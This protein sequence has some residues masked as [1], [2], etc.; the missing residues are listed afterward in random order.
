MTEETDFLT[1]QLLLLS[2]RYAEQS[3]I[4][5]SY[6]QKFQVSMGWLGETE[7]YIGDIDLACIGTEGEEQ[8]RQVSRL[9]TDLQKML[10]G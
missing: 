2:T 4:I 7:R 1:D 6:R 10:A 3:A 8:L 5:E 9:I